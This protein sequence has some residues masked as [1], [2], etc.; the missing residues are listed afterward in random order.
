M[1][2]T[3]SARALRTLREMLEQLG[4]IHPLLPS[5]VG[6]LALVAGA[7]ITDLI[8]KQVLVRTVRAFATTIEH[9]LG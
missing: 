2:D 8:V 7:V 5:G 9:H 4:T 3:I 6:L 1:G